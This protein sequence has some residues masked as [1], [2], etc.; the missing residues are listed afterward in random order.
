MHAATVNIENEPQVVAIHELYEKR[1]DAEA[2]LIQYYRS[3]RSRLGRIIW[4]IE[5]ILGKLEALKDD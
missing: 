3:I 1:E 4:N 5:Q 2:D